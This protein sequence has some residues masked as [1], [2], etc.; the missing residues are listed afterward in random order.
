MFRIRNGWHLLGDKFEVPVPEYI[1]RIGTEYTADDIREGRVVAIDARH[2]EG[3]DRMLPPDID[4]WPAVRFEV[5][6]GAR[7][8]VSVWSVLAADCRRAQVE[9]TTI[10][11][12]IG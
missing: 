2:V 6:V 9:H 12:T 7:R 8:P 10:K 1:D 3:H 11:R 4:T 5:G